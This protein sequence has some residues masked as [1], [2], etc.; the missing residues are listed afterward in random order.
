[1][2]ITNAI[3]AKQA[4][5]P[6]LSSLY[7]VNL[8]AGTTIAGLIMA[9]S[10]L[11]A[12]LY[13]QP[14]LRRLL[15]IAALAFVITPFGQQFQAL[16]QKEL[17]FRPLALAEIPAAIVGA[18]VAISLAAAGAGAAA[19]VWGLVVM[20]AVRAFGLAAYG[21]ARWR[22][23]PRLRR[24]DLRGYVGFG[25]YQMGAQGTRYM[26][27]N[28]DYLLIGYLLGPGAL[29]VYALA[30]QIA[31]RPQVQI[32]PVLNRVAF[33]V[34]ARR[35]RDD[36]ALR[37][38]FVE[39]TRTLSLIN[40]PFLVGV[41]VVAP[42]LIPAVFGERWEESVPLL[43]ILCVLGAFKAL[44]NPEGS[45]YL[46]KVRPDILFWNAVQLL[47]LVT[48]AIL[49]GV[50]AGVVGAAWAHVI[51]VAINFAVN[52]LRIERLIGL[53]LRKYFAALLLPAMMA[54]GMGLIVLA[55]SPV[56][57]AE[58]TREGALVIEVA[59]GMGAY[60]FLVGALDRPEVIRLWR[61]LRARPSE[62][63]ADL[64]AALGPNRRS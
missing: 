30:Y 34:F 41:A 55:A 3:I 51:A 64:D 23:Q 17:D 10:P 42:D 33:P 24:E 22:P 48:G 37:S 31:V 35:Q 5:G 52:R 38:G 45:V 2:G 46:A 8:L 4:S 26:A 12:D 63:P 15:P 1:M 60:A 61:L 9:S 11:I 56:A 39:L 43:Q 36:A 20:T 32:N 58:L 25:M 62:S 16:L 57:H 28:V 13:D 47:V 6:H 49:I 7:W 54:L 14:E 27:T 21:W 40:F 29:G 53:S 44:A 19:L 59:V 50:E 18:A